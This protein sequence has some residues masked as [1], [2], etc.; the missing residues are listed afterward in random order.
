[1]GSTFTLANIQWHNI[2]G[3]LAL[4][5]FGIKLMGDSLTNFAG[6]K[7][8][9]YIE[10]YT[11]NPIMAIFVGV[12]MTGIMQSSS[13][14]T[15]IAISLVR[16]GLMSLEQA[17]GITLG[18]NIGTTV[19]SIL[20]GFDLDYYAYFIILIG[21]FMYMLASKKQ[22]SYAGEII[23]GFGL[24]FIGLNLMGD[25]LKELKNLPG[26]ERI[27]VSMSSTPVFGALVGAIITGV[28]QSSSAIVGIVQTLYA[29]D[30]V[31]LTAALGLVFGAN[32]GTTVTALLASIGASLSARRTSLFHLLFNI[33]VSIVFII[34]IYPYQSLLLLI[35]D[36]FELNK[37]MTIA[38]G[39]FMFNFIGMLIFLPFIN[40]ISKI[41]N[42]I[43]PG[44]DELAINYGR[45][46][47]DD[48]MI[49]TFPAGALKQA[50]LAIESASDLALQTLTTSKE[51]LITGDK[52]YFE[53]VNQIEDLVNQQD[54]EIATYL[55]Q[56]SKEDLSPDL[57]L[58]YSIDIQVQKNFERVSDLAQN[59][60]EY[61]NSIYDVGEKVPEDAMEELLDIYELITHI[62]VNAVEVFK[63][64]DAALFETMKEDE[65]NLNLLE[66]QLRESHFTRLT[67][68]H[69]KATVMT[70]LFV[71]IISTLERIGDHAFNIAQITFKPIKTHSEKKDT[72]QTIDAAPSKN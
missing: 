19:T 64:K 9:T 8:R 70:S 57:I 20:I 65:N 6:T 29:T 3:G 36:K 47:L 54:T 66:Y 44:K 58:E 71:D 34:L 67:T 68:R 17:I 23:I 50:R 55:L 11:S 33:S 63:T 60:A 26:F 51:L 39:H 43:L 32:I 37:L 40:H 18:A 22:M 59:L 62:Y 35:A 49:K 45:V 72:K 5:L 46:E 61:Y 53:K 1:M 12:L 7:I 48:A 38:V 28:I 2:A 42:K 21:V 30:A 13:A 24:L 52:K 25:A 27:V 16:A 69:V 14:T 56:I 10:R 41:L 31:P 15:V 4:F